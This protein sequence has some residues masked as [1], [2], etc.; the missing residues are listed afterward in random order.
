MI[1]GTNITGETFNSGDV[2]RIKT[3]LIP[4][5]NLRKTF[6]IPDYAI[7]LESSGKY[8]WREILPQGYIDPLTGEGV[9][10]PFFNKRRYLFAPI[11]LDVYPNL[12]IESW[13]KNQNTINVFNE[14][15]YSKNATEINTTPINDEQ[16]NNIGKPCQ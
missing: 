11:I 1:E 15:S 12:S 2:F 6:E 10:Y 16:L 9:D 4:N 5:P 3:R 13:E 8:I 7:M 14:I